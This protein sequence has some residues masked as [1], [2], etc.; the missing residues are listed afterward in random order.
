M[1]SHAQVTVL[2][3]NGKYVGNQQATV[4]C[5]QPEA[6]PNETFL[7]ETEGGHVSLRSFTGK[8]ISHK[9]GTVANVG[10]GRNAETFFTLEYPAFG[11]V[12]FKT[13]D[14]RFLAAKKLGGVYL[15]A[16]ASEETVFTLRLLNRPVIA[17]QSVAFNTFVGTMNGKYVTH[18]ATV[19]TFAVDYENGTYAFRGS[20]GAYFSINGNNIAPG[21]KTNFEIRFKGN[22][23]CNI[24]T[25][26]G[27]CLSAEQNGG[28]V[29]T[30]DSGEKETFEF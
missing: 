22:S 20:D 18:K 30:G 26:D 28:F 5:N 3:H 24:R 7:L 16:A 6:G 27:K 14:G 21:A 17:L 23:L 19:E 10:E 25:A 15:A 4:I 12:A 8:Y 13:A 11:R 9:A 2:A 1:D 29:L